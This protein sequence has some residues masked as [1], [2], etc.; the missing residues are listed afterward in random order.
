MQAL[1]NRDLSDNNNAAPFKSSCLYPVSIQVASSC[2]L[3]V[4]TAKKA[5]QNNTNEC[6]VLFQYC[7]TDA[8]N[9]NGV[10]Y[11]FG[12]RKGKSMFNRKP[13]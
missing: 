10:T 13:N 7:L 9:K 3:E 11:Y 8:H 1:L 2:V 5:M 4:L 6:V 12:N